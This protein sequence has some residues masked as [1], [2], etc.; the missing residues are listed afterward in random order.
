MYTIPT[1]PPKKRNHK[2]SID[3]PKIGSNSSVLQLDL[4]ITVFIPP[5]LGVFD[6]FP[7]FE[8]GVMDSEDPIVF[9]EKYY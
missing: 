4:L 6:T 9:C 7:N 5:V 1:P 3:S 8:K 2:I